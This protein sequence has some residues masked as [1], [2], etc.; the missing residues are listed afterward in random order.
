M[1]DQQHRWGG[2][3]RGGGRCAA[4]SLAMLATLVVDGRLGVAADAA[5]GRQVYEKANCVGCHKWHGGGGG[6]YGGAALSL[7]ATQLDRAML[8]EVVHCGR[9]ATGMPYHDRKAYQATECYGGMTKADLAGDMPPKAATFLRDAEI[10]AVVDYVMAN[11][12]GKAEPGYED[13][14]AYWGPDHKECE[15]MPH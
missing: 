10:E 4:L 2:S 11:L 6:G 3:S 7:R 8:L 15:S 14:I 5:L 12:Q 13:C 1:T 9:P